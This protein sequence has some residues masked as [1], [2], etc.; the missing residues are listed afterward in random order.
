[1]TDLGTEPLTRLALELRGIAKSYGNTVALKD[2]DFSCQVGEIH[3]LIGENGAGKSTLVKILSGLV[4]PDAGTIVI[5]GRRVQ[6]HSPEEALRAGV[7]TAFQELTLVPH[8]TVAQNLMIRREAH[9]RLGLISPRRTSEEAERLLE[10]WG[11]KDIAPDV[12]VSS[13]SLSDRQRIEVVRTFSRKP[14]IA[15]LDEAT[16]ALGASEVDW[17]VTQIARYREAGGTIVYISHRMGEVRQLC[18]RCTVL[19]DGRNVET[20]PTSDHTDSEVVDM[21]AGKAVQK[22]YAVRGTTHLEHNAALVV[23]NLTSPPALRDASFTLHKGEI[24]GIA[25]LHGHGQKELFM[26][27]FGASPSKGSIAV[28]GKPVR[29]RG[30]HDAIAAHIGISL[31]PEERKTEGLM[32]AL[33]GL[34]NLT[35][36]SLG[37]FSA[38]GFIRRRKERAAAASVL[39]RV[40]AV[41]RAL[42]KPVSTL[43]GGNQQKIAIGKWLLAGAQILLMY[44]PTRGVDVET[45]AEIF[46]LMHQLTEQGRSIL[47]Y[48]TDVEELVNVADRTIV[49]Y[50]GRTTR[51]LRG[52]EATMESIVEAMLGHSAV[53]PA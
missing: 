23:E 34:P 18:D 24:L 50:G 35:L 32:T 26:A 30:P 21:M 39:R 6:L 25:G 2:A 27:L 3:G 16:A 52:E 31:V 33:A 47:F 38:G 9:N 11:A 36:P 42:D 19:R 29:L 15:L 4:Q 12:P 13:L 41:T 20:F 10:E 37:Q 40:N 28:E 5:A 49:M 22:V 43:S 51:E 1:M 53:V 7:A 44:D 17:L 46:S 14:A 8:M 48:S 45:K